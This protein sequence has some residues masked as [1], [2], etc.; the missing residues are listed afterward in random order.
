MTQNHITTDLLIRDS[1]FNQASKRAL[2]TLEKLRGNMERVA[3][4]ARRMFVVAAGGATAATVTFAK[5]EDEMNRVKGLSSATEEEFSS[6]NKTAR[7]LGK[8]TEF[9]ANQAAQ[10]MSAFALQ[11]FKTTD[12]ISAM[13]KVLDLA[14]VG[15]LGMAQAA[16]I[17]AGIMKGMKI[18]V[19]ELTQVVDVLAKTATNSATD[20]PQLGE[21]MKAL[22]PVAQ[23]A[24]LS[25]EESLGIIRAFSDVMIQGGAAGT[26]LRNVLLRI[27]KQPSEVAK[28][29]KSLGVSV[30]TSTGNLRSMG[31]IVDDLN[32]ALAEKDSVT[33]NAIISDIAGLRAAAAFTELLSL[34]GDTIRQYTAELEG[35]SGTTDRLSEIM[36]SGFLKG[37][38]LPLTSAISEL[39]I[40]VGELLV[41]NLRLAT[42]TIK[43][44]VDRMNNLSDT[45]TKLVSVIGGVGIAMVGLAASSTLII[46]TIKRLIDLSVILKAG[47]LLLGSTMRRALNGKLL[48]D[49]LAV[50][51][52]ALIKFV[53]RGR[54]AIVAMQAFLATA[55]GAAIVYA[56]LAASLALAVTQFGKLKE[57][58]PAVEQGTTDLTGAFAELKKARD[59][60]GKASTKEDKEAAINREIEAM[61]RLIE[62]L[63]KDSEKFKSPTANFVFSEEEIEAGIQQNESS[64]SRIQAQLAAAQERLAGAVDGPSSGIE[65]NIPRVAELSEEQKKLQE[66]VDKLADSM[67]FEADT[68]G[69]NSRQA[70]IHKL[71]LEGATAAQ[72]R[73]LEAIDATVTGLEEQQDEMEKLN[74]ELE[75]KARKD[76][77]AAKRVAD[78]AD[79]S[80]HELET[81]L[82]LL[83]G[84]IT[85]QDIEANR[86]EFLGLEEDQIQ[87]ILDLRLAI[88][89][90]E[91]R[92]TKQKELQNAL[93]NQS[94]KFESG[95]GLFKRIQES[96]ASVSS[97]ANRT[98]IPGGESNLRD[99][100]RIAAANDAKQKEIAENTKGSKTEAGKQTTL[101]SEIRDSLSNGN[102]AIFGA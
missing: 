48:A 91:E 8:S 82:A 100:E 43:A 3:A 4:T 84:Q 60:E 96:V 19:N 38:V 27:Q 51:E 94:A 77:E 73:H 57:S 22:G 42:D 23:A 31:D 49:G 52:A 44:L 20:I 81:K 64:I 14:T 47:M 66:S 83:R 7:D 87:K 25:L 26:A 40:K 99:Q 74:R 85:E 24:G 58:I 62:L 59:A 32:V 2:S 54:E 29:F 71:K 95:E 72:I 102:V 80:V 39:G 50:A 55:A 16:E 5:F 33:R 78:I 34:G 65:L 67:Q 79:S 30:K 88:S 10:A 89:D 56:G 6:L 90:E 61:Q 9:S 75:E 1:Q 37:A 92:I 69:L 17:T 15:Q 12:I 45:T 101:L 28:A 13:P 68:F 63:N 93:E 35:A 97:T 86:L 41:P 46:G 21:A 53:I 11:G 18:P 70:E 76:E 98:L 36:R